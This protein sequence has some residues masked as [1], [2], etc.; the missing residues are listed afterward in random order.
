M[1]SLHESLTSA[2]KALS[3]PRGMKVW[4]LIALIPLN[5]SLIL[6]TVQI[7]SVHDSPECNTKSMHENGC[8]KG[9]CASP[10]F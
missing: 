7:P 4:N 5:S 6:H 8:M 3:F 1:K 2:N 10:G 9:P